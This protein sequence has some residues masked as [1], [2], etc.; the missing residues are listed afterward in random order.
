M[1]FAAAAGVRLSALAMLML[2]VLPAA[3]AVASVA[4]QVRALQGA[5]NRERTF[6]M[7]NW[8]QPVKDWFDRD[9]SPFEYA[10]P[11]VQPGELVLEVGLGNYE[12]MMDT[13]TDAAR[14]AVRECLQK[15]RLLP[16]R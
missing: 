4:A 3:D 9:R 1:K 2:A 7:H 5:E 10:E 11:E 16:S 14:P 15:L 6:T 8:Y 13:I 12:V